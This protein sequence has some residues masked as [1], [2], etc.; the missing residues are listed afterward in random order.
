MII[1][2][3]FRSAWS[4]YHS[5]IHG[6]WREDLSLSQSIICIPFSFHVYFGNGTTVTEINDVEQIIDFWLDVLYSH[7][8][9]FHTL[10]NIGPWVPR[11]EHVGFHWC[12]FE[13]WNSQTCP[14]V[15]AISQTGSSSWLISHAVFNCTELRLRI[16]QCPVMVIVQDN[17]LNFYAVSSRLSYYTSFIGVWPKRKQILILFFDIDY[18]FVS[19]TWNLRDCVAKSQLNSWKPVPRNPRKWFCNVLYS[20]LINTFISN[21]IFLK[22][23]L[24]LGLWLTQGGR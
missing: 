7:A 17:T 20:F 15:E 6:Y 5:S 23:T 9:H 24:F 13:C 22:I 19:S 2:L 4:K 3:H 21:G 1:D 10:S 18:Q 14:P 16:K 11:F 12:Y 8:T